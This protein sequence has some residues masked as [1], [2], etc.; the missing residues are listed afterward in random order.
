MQWMPF[1]TVT[2]P[3]QGAVKVSDA[4]VNRPP[5]RYYRAKMP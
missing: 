1:T 4:S 2:I 5:V 3:A